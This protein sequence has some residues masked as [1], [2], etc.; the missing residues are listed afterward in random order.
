[1]AASQ[2][3]ADPLKSPRKRSEDARLNWKSG[4]R[5]FALYRCAEQLRCLA[6]IRRMAVYAA[7][8]V[9]RQCFIR[10]Q[11]QRPVGR[12][13]RGFGFAQFY[14]HPC[15]LREVFGPRRPKR[16]GALEQLYRRRCLAGCIGQQGQQEMGMRIAR[17]RVEE[18]FAEFFRGGEFTACECTCGILL[19]LLD[20]ARRDFR[21][22]SRHG[23]VIQPW[24]A[25]GIA[26]A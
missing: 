22:G 1:M 15:Q 17:S 3:S 8:G 10:L 4:F 9:E 7:D 21:H 5:R 23:S 16:H 2:A 12:C 19:P 26:S 24:L 14:Q 18:L 6:V 20:N 11:F 25:Y 13:T